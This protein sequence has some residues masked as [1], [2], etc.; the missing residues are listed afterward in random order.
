MCKRENLS[1][2]FFS[3]DKLSRDI[4]SEKYSVVMLKYILTRTEQK[5]ANKSRA[6]LNTSKSEHLPV[7]SVKQYG[8]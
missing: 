1:D 4:R 6:K 2:N 8:K 3:S 7:D 5:Q